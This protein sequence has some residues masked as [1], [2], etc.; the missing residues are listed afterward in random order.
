MD[1]EKSGDDNN[2]KENIHF[3]DDL[4]LVSIIIPV[5][6][7]ANYMQEAIDSALAQSYKNIEIIVVNDGSNDDGKT[8]NIALS[9]RDKIRYFYK[10]NG[11]CASALNMGIKNMQGQYFSWLSH[12]D[13]YLPDKI[14]HQINILNK[15]DNK[16]TIIYG[17]YELIDK[18]SFSLHFVR[19]ENKYSQNKL[20]ISLFP[21]LRGLVHGCTLL[22][23]VKY[24]HEIG[25]FDETLPS[26]QDY[27]LWFKFFRVASIHFDNRILVKS[28][29]HSEQ[30]THKILNHLNECEELWSG[31]LKEVTE[32]EMVKM[33]G[34][35]YL[36][37]HRTASFLKD[38]PYK[39]SENLARLMLEEAF[40]KIKVSV[41]MPVYNRI[42]FAIEAIQSV[43]IQT[44]KN[45]ELIIVDD[46]STEDITELSKICEQDS[47]IIYIPQKNKGPAAARNCGIKKATGEYIAFLDSD[48]LFTQDKLKYQLRLMEENES[49][50][51]HT[52][53][54]QINEESELIRRISSGTFKGKVFPGIISCCPIAMPTVMAKTFILKSNL[55]P[56]N[57]KIAEDCCNWI[58]IASQ[59]IVGGIDVELSKIRIGNSTT[60]TN[61]Y[62]LMKG[63]INIACFAIDH[64]YASHYTQEISS[65]LTNALQIVKGLNIPYTEPPV[66][67]VEIEELSILQQCK[68]QVP[69]NITL[70]AHLIHSLRHNGIR[71]TWSKIRRRL[72]L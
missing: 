6:N 31:F 24:F 57:I 52:S 33:E 34:S 35:P 2:M 46:G 71:I 66:E 56:E 70:F 20:N 54:H 64:I 53:Y 27:A 18:K 59:Y 65:L 13:I 8:E 55:F 69:K 12:D 19:P 21:L 48:D 49:E 62:K 68:Q 37:L 36:F 7:G 32:E 51:S 42:N 15:L 41:I 9:Y 72:K 26:T 60:S 4:P 50:F 47:R 44:H 11:G 43:L 22:I 25:I 5:Y 23:P 29:V 63:Y 67:K 38:T 3:Q 17:G 10:E 40:K 30:G 45:F 14:E 16:D 28:R 61:P 39:K 1:G 58:S